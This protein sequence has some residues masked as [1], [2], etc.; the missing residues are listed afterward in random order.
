MAYVVAF[1]F[2]YNSS[3]INRN[4]KPFNPLLG[5]TY[6]LKNLNLQYISEQVCHHPP[7]SAG[8]LFL[9]L[10]E[11]AS[12]QIINFGKI[13]MLLPNSGANHWK[14]ILQESNIS[15]L[16]NT[17]IIFFIKHLKQE[18]IILFL[19]KFMQIFQEY[20]FLIFRNKFTKTTKLEML[21]F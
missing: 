9:N 20:L 7:I 1:S 15:S 19:E 21:E 13:A 4:L 12:T 18:F 6:E 8:S 2:S 10:Q 16:T 5:E 3:V 11:F 17:M 14:S